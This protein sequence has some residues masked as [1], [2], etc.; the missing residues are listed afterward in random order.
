MSDSLRE[1]K[2]ATKS[3][4]P[5]LVG[6]GL[7]IAVLVL[8]AT[9]FLLLKTTHVVEPV[10]LKVG[11]REVTKALYDKYVDIGKKTS[12]SEAS[13]KSIL[14]EY[15]KN[16]AMAAKYKLDIPDTYVALSRD[17][18]LADAA[19]QEAGGSLASLRTSEDEVTQ[20]RLYNTAFRNFVREA[21]Q[22]GWAIVLYDIPMVSLLDVDQE[23]ARATAAAEKVREQLVNK[24]VTP[25]EAVDLAL[26]YRNSE[27]VQTGMYFIREADG[28]VLGQYSGGVYTRL[29]DPTFLPKY[30]K[31]KDV[32][33]TKVTV[34][35]DKS[36]FFAD[37]L[38][39]Q[40]K[41]ADLPV[42]IDT[43]KAKMKVVD[44]VK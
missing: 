39:K 23:K 31:D 28:A 15:E 30:L 11:D 42:K 16:K 19:A 26:E 24:E 32:G 21:S 1:D 34:Y 43:E 37:I 33:V 38:L 4:A 27:P 35:D 22:G 10:A 8:V 25:A 6:V 12:T 36:A 3:N 40:K 9:V 44:Y 18:M 13:V 17:D 41:Q 7:A 14:V 5:L 29:L 2:K 20:L